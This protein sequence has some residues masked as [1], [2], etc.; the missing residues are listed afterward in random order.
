MLFAVFISAGTPVLVPECTCLLVRG[1]ECTFLGFIAVYSGYCLF[2][3][4]YFSK[5]D[6]CASEA[7]FTGKMEKM[8]NFRL[9]Q[10]L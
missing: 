3:Q 9:N 2:A 4:E 7:N 10:Q 8:V 1:L 5:S 6:A